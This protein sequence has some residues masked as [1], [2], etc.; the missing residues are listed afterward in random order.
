[1]RKRE[2][3]KANHF[4]NLSALMWPLLVYGC[5]THPVTERGTG[6]LIAHKIINQLLSTLISH[7]D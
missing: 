7:G 4:S 3:E 2:R 6:L 1:M 5:K